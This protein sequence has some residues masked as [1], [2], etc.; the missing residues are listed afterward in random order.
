M[1]KKDGPTAP[2]APDPAATAAAQEKTNIASATAQANLNRINQVTPQGSLTYSQNGTNA[3]GTP[4]YTQTQTLSADEQA[5]YDQNNQIA[6][7]LGGLATNNIGR[8][9]DAQAKPFTY[10]GMTALRTSVG[11]GNPRTLQDGPGAGNYQDGPGAGTFKD[12]P[13]VGAIQ[14]NA[15]A[16]QI[17]SATGGE[18]GPVQSSLNYSGLT[19]LPG[20]NDFSADQRRAADSVYSQVASRLDPQW[21]QSDSDLKSSLAAQG[22]SENSDAYRRAIDN[23][24]RSKNDAYNQAGWSAQAAGSAEQSR[25]FGLAMSARQQ[26][27]NETDTQGT[28]ANTAEQQAYAQKMGILDQQNTAQAQDFGQH[29]SNVQLNNAAEALKFDQG[30]AQTATHN[31]N[32]AQRVAEEAAQVATRNQNEQQRIAEAAAQTA[33]HNTNQN[34]TFN[35]DSADATFNNQARQ[36]QITEAAYLRNLPI[37]DIASL[38]G[39]GGGVA[40]PDFNPVA[41]VGVA[42]PDYMGLVNSNFTA[43]NEKYKADQA[44]R[45][46]GLGSVFGMAGTAAGAFLSDRRFKENIRRIGTLPNGLATYAFNYIGNALQQFGVMAQEVLSVIPDAVLRDADGTLFVDYGK[47]YA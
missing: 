31:Q 43:A 10:D 27:Q 12:G 30:A 37:N 40:T 46:Q 24:G 2:A 20:T 22:I 23:Q 28:F 41:Q 36:Q 32:E 18:M 33:T 4:Q 45:S 47:V 34:T 42:A 7:A 15:Q 9:A 21:S 29:L 14:N 44:A 11:D 3:D 39:T 6:K 25:L 16:G 17:R 1:S 19:A 5:K 38:L 8:V 26:G 13:G 35:Q